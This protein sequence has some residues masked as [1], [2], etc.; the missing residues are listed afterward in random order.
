MSGCTETV[1]FAC[2]IFWHPGPCLPAQGSSGSTVPHGISSSSIHFTVK[3]SNK[4]KT[5][6]P[7]QCHLLIPFTLLTFSFSLSFITNVH[8]KWVLTTCYRPGYFNLILCL[9][10]S[11]FIIPTCYFFI[12]VLGNLTYFPLCKKNSSLQ[13]PWRADNLATL[14]FYCTS[15]TFLLIGRVCT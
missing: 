10:I 6:C 8:E 2:D 13:G 7:S 1:I 11:D 15:L 3:D 14:V 5:L 9:K 4:P 12:C